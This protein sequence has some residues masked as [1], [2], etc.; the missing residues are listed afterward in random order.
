M[1]IRVGEGT[2]GLEG[3]ALG[4]QGAPPPPCYSSLW[5]TLNLA[6]NWK[7]A[8]VLQFC[9]GNYLCNE[10]KMSLETLDNLTSMFD[11]PVDRIK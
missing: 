10:H 9:S 4:Q 7:T 6:L 2:L 5:E 3:G 8:E 1:K 11:Q